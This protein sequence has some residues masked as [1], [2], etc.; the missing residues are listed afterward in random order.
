MAATLVALLDSADQADISAT[1]ETENWCEQR[2]TNASRI[3]GS[4]T[5]DSCVIS[6]LLLQM[7]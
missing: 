2:W 5:D 3:Q 1:V 7:L 4:P 6:D